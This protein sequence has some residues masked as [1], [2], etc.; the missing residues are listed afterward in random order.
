MTYRCPVCEG[1][2]APSYTKDGY[3]YR[4]CKACGMLLVADLLQAETIHGHY[5]EAYFEAAAADIDQE[6]LGYPSYREAQQSLRASFSRKLDLVCSLKPEGRMLDV[7]AAYGTFLSLASEHFECYGLDVSEYA[8]SVARDEFGMNVRQGSIEGVTP[9]EDGFFDVV[10]M[11]D[12]I[13]HL[14]EPLAGLKE[15]LRILK[16]GGYLAIS[17][18]DAEHWLPRLLGRNWWGLAAPLHLNHFTKRSMRI[19]L[20][21]VA[22]FDGIR[23]VPDKREYGVGEIVSHLGVS[24]KRNW[25]ANFGKRIER[26]IFGEIVITVARPEQFIAIAQRKEQGM[27]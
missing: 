5:S 21:R 26:S 25:L 11:W 9:F 27:P 1:D 23:F 14:M 18:D 8:A 24:F 20:E 4:Q 3:T 10:V 7:G 13:E 22:G 12:V 16:P 6:R 19:A 17:T 2:T 15:V